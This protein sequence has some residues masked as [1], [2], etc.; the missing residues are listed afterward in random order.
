MTNNTVPRIVEI[1]GPAGAGKTTLCQAL[2]RGCEFIHLGNFPD[3]RKISA[4]PFFIWNGLQILPALRVLPQRNSR[5]LTRREFAWLSILNGWPHVLQK[6]LKY[7]KTIILDQGPVYLLTELGEF[8]SESLQDHV[9]EIAW[10]GIYERWSTALDMIIWLDA[11]DR[12][13]LDRINARQKE[14]PIKNESAEAIYKFLSRSR[15]AYEQIIANLSAYR[16]DMKI[17]RFDTSKK[18]PA[19]IVNQLLGV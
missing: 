1:I 16:P 15:N 11:T 18:T 14:H 5:K 12:C 7:K 19:Q 4:A 9:I 10:Q 2:S 17:L 8:D 13:L 3:V 6:E